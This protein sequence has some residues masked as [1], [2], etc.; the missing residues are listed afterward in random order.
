MDLISEFQT[1]PHRR[2]WEYFKKLGC[3]PDLI[4][5]TRNVD[6]I[7]TG[8]TYRP[9][10]DAGQSSVVI[11]VEDIYG[12]L[13][14][15]VA[16]LPSNTKKWYTRNGS[17]SVLGRHELDTA[18][19]FQRP[20]ILRSSPHEWLL[21]GCT[22]VVPLNDAATYHFMGIKE[23]VADQETYDKFMDSL[24]THFPIP[25]LVLT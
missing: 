11:P 18:I 2:A 17:S 9:T 8:E 23:I 16:Y 1:Y 15:L 3:D 21:A 24:Q 4:L 20:L 10:L 6:I 14:D 13:C 12:N 5:Q 25:K 19:T 7:T 22:G